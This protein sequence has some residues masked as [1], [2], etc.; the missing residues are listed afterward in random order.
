MGHNQKKKK[1]SYFWV[2][3]CI[4][5]GHQV[6]R[7]VRHPPRSQGVKN[8]PRF[9]TCFTK[10]AC[11]RVFFSQKAHKKVHFLPKIHAKKYFSQKSCKKVHF[12]PKEH[13]KKSIFFQKHS[14]KVHF[15]PKSS[16]SPQIQTWLQA[17]FTVLHDSLCPVIHHAP[18][19]AV[20]P[21]PLWFAFAFAFAQIYTFQ[22]LNSNFHT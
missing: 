12:L 5:R 16:P 3:G 11:K 19:F 13:T 20:I 17:W 1:F 21:R 10:K 22:Y 8:G 6:V 9:W 18:R 2:H 15:L 7:G 4:S 14:L